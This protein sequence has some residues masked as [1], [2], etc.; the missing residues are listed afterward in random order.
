MGRR[1][2]GSQLIALSGKQ[3]A[4]REETL[5]DYLS[6]YDD[7][8]NLGRL[9]A[10]LDSPEQIRLWRDFG[11]ADA[12]I[13]AFL[14]SG[15]IATEYNT[16]IDRFYGGRLS[17]VD[18]RT[19]FSASSFRQARSA[20]PSRVGVSRA[21]SPDDVLRIVDKLKAG[22]RRSLVFRGQT[23]NHSIARPAPNNHFVIEGLGEVSLFPSVWR[24]FGAAHW[25]GSHEFLMP[26][27]TF[28]KRV[29]LSQFDH[30]EVN[31]RLTNLA[32]A[33][34]CFWNA[35]D[36]EDCSDPYLQSYGR[37]LADIEFGACYNLST[38]L[39][40]LL[41]HYGLVSPVL[42]LSSDLH[43]ALFFATN[44]LN[45]EGG[46][47]DYKFCGTN[48]RQSILYIF[49]HHEEVMAYREDRVFQELNPLRPIRQSC[50]VVGSEEY[51]MNLPADFLYHAI[52]LDYD[53][54]KPF[55]LGAD[56]IFPSPNEDHFLAALQSHAPGTLR[57]HVT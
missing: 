43:T 51:A 28:W 14:A 25:S 45:H 50:V 46:G 32:G 8:S 30:Q 52:V 40:T 33:E 22:A 38:G 53:Q 12:E 39:A 18:R 13:S 55:S 20:G 19:R 56:E 36:M 4:L 3:G 41:Q 1:S 21:T 44:R 15:Y 23:R 54:A 57:D 48:N 11:F 31:R 26:Y 17:R 16:I 5:V 47:L 10:P 2:S 29:L 37:A 27:T 42:D 34:A 7:R 35:F 6:Y 49:E 9:V 24:K